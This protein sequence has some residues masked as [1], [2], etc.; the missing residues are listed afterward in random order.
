MP[1]SP[2]AEM[3]RENPAF[4]GKRLKEYY[5]ARNGAAVRELLTPATSMFGRVG[6]KSPAAPGVLG[7]G[8]ADS[9]GGAGATSLVP[10]LTD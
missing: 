5:L 4:L 2:A 7:F 3:A 10:L 9:E 8:T 1:A 6:P